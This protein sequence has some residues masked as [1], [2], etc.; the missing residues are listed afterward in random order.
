MKK[1][2]ALAFAA[3][4]SVGAS[5]QLI[6]SNTMTE[7]ESNNY[8]RFAVGYNSVSFN[9]DIDESMTGVSLEW[10][11]GFPV[12]TSTPLFIETGIGAS[13]SW[14]SKDDVDYRFATVQVP[15]NLV[16]KYELTDGI[17]IAPYAG[18]YFRGNLLAEAEDDDETYNWF[19]DLED[20]GLEAKRFSYGW[21][22]GVGVEF[23]KLYL[24]IGYSSDLN[25]L[26][27]IDEKFD[28][29][30]RI[31]VSSKTSTF[32]AKIGINF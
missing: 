14:K 24:G 23:N 31:K 16:Y 18:V 30:D 19:D 9:D 2:F 1:L 12:S 25:N 11:K 22:I 21:Q 10:V 28:D 7:Q 26:I 27:D 6:S 32:A 29:Y 17:K 4:M 15:V 8:S 20:E 13:Y 5:A 3:I